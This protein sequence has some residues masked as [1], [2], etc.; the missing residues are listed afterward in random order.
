VVEAVYETDSL[1]LCQASSNPV[2][3]KIQHWQLAQNPT[4]IEPEIPVQHVMPYERIV[5]AQV[6]YEP[7]DR[8]IFEIDFADPAPQRGLVDDDV[9]LQLS[10]PHD[11]EDDTHTQ[12]LLAHE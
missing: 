1:E 3:G 8:G 10:D 5:R 6:T 7:H 11:I 12:G 9:V 2:L 4:C